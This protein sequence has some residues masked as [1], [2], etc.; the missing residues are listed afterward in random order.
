MGLVDEPL[1]KDDQLNPDTPLLLFFLEEEE[2]DPV[3]VLALSELTLLDGLREELEFILFI[4][5]C[6]EFER[7]E[8]F[9]LVEIEEVGAKLFILEDEPK[10]GIG[11][12]FAKFLRDEE[13]DISVLEEEEE[14]KSEV[15]IVET[16]L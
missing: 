16:I 12:R 5:G 1:S 3:I 15:Q 2:V 11:K 6:N 9:E 7:D 4:L 14:G 10:F 13:V 8:V